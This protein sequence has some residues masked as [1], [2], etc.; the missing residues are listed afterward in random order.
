[1]VDLYMNVAAKMSSYFK[2]AFQLLQYSITLSILFVYI[3]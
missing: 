1:M 2:F 3:R